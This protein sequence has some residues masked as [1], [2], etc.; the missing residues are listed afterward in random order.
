MKLKP[1]D[2]NTLHGIL[3]SDA[4]LV[5]KIEAIRLV[6]PMFYLLTPQPKPT[7]ENLKWDIEVK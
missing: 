7:G 6:N 1:P 2:P 3:I 4:P 5:D